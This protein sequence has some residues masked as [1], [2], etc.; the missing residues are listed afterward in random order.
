MPSWFYLEKAPT[1]PSE[2]VL[3]YQNICLLVYTS[4]YVHILKLYLVAALAGTL[5]FLAIILSPLCCI[6]IPRFFCIKILSTAKVSH[7]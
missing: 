2:L 3:L 7:L 1:A 4:I 6:D 5:V